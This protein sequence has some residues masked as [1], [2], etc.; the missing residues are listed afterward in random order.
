MRLS[1]RN[2]LA[3]AAGLERFTYDRDKQ[4]VGIVHLGLGAFHRAH[5]AVYTDLAMSEGDRDWAICGVSL[6]SPS[7]R[8]QLMPQDGLYSVTARESRGQQTRIIGAIKSVLVSRDD[9][10]PAIDALAAADTK[11]VTLT[12][13]EKGY[14]NAVGGGL[15]TDA[16]EIAADLAGSAP[17]RTVFGLLG[18]GLARRRAAGLPGVTLVSCDNLVGN[19][20]ILSANL[21]QF[22]ER[23]DPAT[24]RWFAA[25]C[26]SPASMVDRIVPATTGAQISE[27]EQRYGFRDEA[28]VFTET[29]SQWVIEDRFAG[30]RPR[31]E[32][33][34]AQFVA[35]VKPYE[36]AKL[37]M[38]NGAHSALAYIGLRSRYTFVHEAVA[39]Q[40]IGQLVRTLMLDEAA[41]TLPHTPGL[42]PGD[43]VNR[44][45]A[46]FSN[47]SLAHRLD[48]IAMDGSQKIQQRWLP[49]LAFHQRQGRHCPALLEALAAWIVHI[50]PG[51]RDVSDPMVKT[52]SDLWQKGADE[53][54]GALFGPS[55]HFAQ[56]WTASPADLK[57][58]IAHV[59]SGKS[60]QP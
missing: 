50:R 38:L 37:R 45:I 60:G 12:V 33:G 53:V 26:T 46:R 18:A 42:D 4:A 20:P 1:S 21:L 23:T 17:K 24:A 30:P 15:A 29:F 19:G 7:A 6:R 51:A 25:E 43:Y 22:L 32:L 59:A 2:F 10:L 5:Q 49:T 52:F 58:I 36:Q 40:R 3:E 56:S 57:A 13:T 44:L 54:V 55:G 47:A 9:S 27:L 48:Q 34:G 14:F 39:D 31:W 11:I 35:D 16:P 41:P 8:D 28:A